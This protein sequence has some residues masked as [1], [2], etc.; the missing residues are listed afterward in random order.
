MI[1]K[2]EP[3]MGSEIERKFLVNGDDWR[4]QTARSGVLRQG[5]LAT[6]TGATVRVR[7]EG[8]DAWLTIKGPTQGIQRAEFEYAIP[9]TDAEAMLALCQSGR[10]EKT[11][12]RVP[13]GGKVWEIDEFAGDNE[14]LVVAE[15]ELASADDTVDLPPWIGRE[16]SEDPRFLNANLSQHPFRTWSSAERQ[17][18]Q[19]APPAHASK[20]PLG[21]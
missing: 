7:I 11:R 20:D 18:C 19:H 6:G 5:Y 2:T 3:S 10:I 13:L 8:D 16:V 15:V 9:R 17:E 14:G 12:H 21:E 4:T 1:G